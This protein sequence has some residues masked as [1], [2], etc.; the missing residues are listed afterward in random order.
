MRSRLYL[1]PVRLIVCLMAALLSPNLQAQQAKQE[2][3]KQ[4]PVGNTPGQFFVLEEPVT[5]ASVRSLE[6]SVQSYIRKEL[7]KGFAPVVVFEFRSRSSADQPASRFGAILELCEFLSRRLVGARTVVGFVPEPLTGYIALAPLACQEVIFQTDATIGPILP[8]DADALTT[9]TVRS[10]VSELASSI[11]RSPDLYEG[12]VDNGL[13]V[14]EVITNDNVTHY[15]TSERLEAFA[16]SH[17]IVHQQKAWPDQKVRKLD[18]AKARGVISRLTVNNSLEILKVYRLPQEALR[19]DPTLGKR[20]GALWIKLEGKLDNF[21]LGYIKR[22]LGLIVATSADVVV[23]EIDARCNDM[24]VAKNLASEIDRLSGVNTIAYVKGKAEGFTVLPLL[25]CEMILVHEGSLTGDVYLQNLLNDAK[26]SGLPPSTVIDE[27]TRDALLTG[28]GHGHSSGIIKG[29]FNPKTTVIEALDLKS[30][31]L[32]FVDEDDAKLEPERFQKRRVIKEKDLI[33]T[34]NSTDAVAYGFASQE[35]S[36]ESL[37]A[38]LGLD[39]SQIMMIGPS[40]VDILV[41]VLNNRLMTGFILTMGLFLLI[42]EFKLP[43]V[44]LPAIG[45]SVCFMLFFWSHYL[46]GTADQL[47]ILL[48]AIGLIFMAIEL[49]VFPGFGIFG[50]TGVILAVLSIV[51]ASHTFI[52]PSDS[53]QYRE[54][55]GTL[56]QLLISLAGGVTGIIWLSRNLKKMPLLRHLVLSPIDG[57]ALESAAAEK[58]I[59]GDSELNLSHL[60]GQIGKST[61]P[62]RPTGKALFGDEIV[63]ATAA[64]GSIEANEPIEVTGTRGLRVIVRKSSNK[65]LGSRNTI[66]D[67]FRFDEDLFKP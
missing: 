26:K 51:L 57:F 21:K 36:T 17:A 22:K 23:F 58:L 31:G 34:L 16:R 24:L 49:F 29:L 52:W 4:Q 35:D 44:G 38:R 48:F 20:K 6:S 33:W 64:T 62:L 10:F 46:S 27:L 40:W 14:I 60:I 37:Q 41:A 15:V 55:S 7:E 13:E 42:L 3:I 66:E 28:R 1:P 9:K 67:S 59:L 30:G 56:I 43:G 45:A 12:L 25:A 54:M 47:E 65:S 2:P 19:I 5:E 50:L 39:P 18:E 63:D 53:S 61:T 8:Q 11:G 32:V